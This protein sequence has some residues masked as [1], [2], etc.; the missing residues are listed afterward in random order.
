M[1]NQKILPVTLFIVLALGSNRVVY[2]NAC[3]PL[4]LGM[5]LPSATYY[6][7]AWMFVD[8]M[9]KSLPFVSRNL[10]GRE[11]TEAIKTM[12]KDKNGYPLILPA[13]VA[14]F[15]E[16]QYVQTVLGNYGL[17][18][19]R[20][21]LYY[22]GTGDIHLGAVD[23]IDASIPGK[24]EFDFPKASHIAQG[25]K[26]KISLT[27]KSSM[28]ED[29]V[30]NIRVIR[31]GFSEADSEK[32]H[33]L[34]HQR[35]Q[36]FST[37]RFMNT[38]RTNRSQQ[39]TI[40]DVV[41]KQAAT[42]YEGVSP[43]YIAKIA[44]ENNSHVWIS[45]PH[46]ADDEF[47]TT[48]AQ[49]LKDE[50]NPNA[51]IY[52]EYSNEVWNR[53]FSDRTV[54]GELKS[55][56][57]T[58]V[59]SQG[60]ANPDIAIRGCEGE[61]IH[62]KYREANARQYTKRAL[63][64]FQLFDTVYEDDQQRLVSVL[65]GQAASSTLTTIIFDALNDPAVNPNAYQVD[66]YAIAPYF[67][68]SFT[69]KLLKAKFKNEII[70][71]GS[72]D[73]ISIL[74]SE[75]TETQFLDEM[76]YIIANQIPETISM[77]KQLT[78]V[79]GMKLLAYEGGQHIAAL[80][81]YPKTDEE[82]EIF[83]EYVEFTGKINR[84]PQMETLYKEYFNTWFEQGGQDFMVFSYISQNG[85]R[86][87][88]WGILET[89]N[90]A[91]EEAPKYRALRELLDNNCP[92]NTETTVEVNGLVYP[93]ESDISVTPNQAM[94]VKVTLNK[95]NVSYFS[96][97]IPGYLRITWNEINHIQMDENICTPIGN[98]WT[99]ARVECTDPPQGMTINYTD[100][101]VNNLK[102]S[103]AYTVTKFANGDREVQRQ[104]FIPAN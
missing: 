14:G 39:Q 6:N 57:Y 70:N 30:H 73:G 48:F 64:I 32:S 38:Q 28:E 93:N 47:V 36:G 18:Q 84:H 98:K 19:G 83:N 44:N 25:I 16:P 92:I 35:L 3:E 96:H 56:Q 99:I 101:M 82:R 29:P 34:F 75:I 17:P 51:K 22:E 67:G 24:I 41:L 90:Q 80:G 4:P 79:Q 89:Q 20:Y 74:A 10:Y 65:S 2:A 37:L 9:K 33:P 103:K 78:D 42:H 86:S 50:L 91:I 59:T 11:R 95:A 66:A 102:K 100:N 31:P 54:K 71:L 97:R 76:A 88:S 13:T 81:V 77:Q 85:A 94:S 7:P 63:E 26:S 40:D 87:G 68:G 8:L 72:L 23:N 104:Y 46:L 15:S 69:R 58:Y 49:T 55:G 52:I 1:I 61:K 62:S 43:Y 60:C 5:N 45:I 21:S 27:I 12:A 53:L